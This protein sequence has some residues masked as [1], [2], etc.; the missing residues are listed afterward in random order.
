MHCD[1]RTAPQHP[2]NAIQKII[3][4]MTIN[5]IGTE[6]TFAY[7]SASCTSPVFA[8]IIP[9]IAINAIPPICNLEKIV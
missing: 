8:I 5:M 7:L 4:P 2:K 6:C 1:S 3:D 9:P